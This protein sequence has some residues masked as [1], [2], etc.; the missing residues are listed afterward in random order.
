MDNVMDLFTKKSDCCLSQKDALFCY[1]MS[2]MT[3]ANENENNKSYFKLLFVEF[4]EMIGRVADFK[5]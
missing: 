3:V 2:K 1:G 4:L 5:F